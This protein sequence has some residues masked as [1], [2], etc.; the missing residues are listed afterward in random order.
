MKT[1]AALLLAT[2]SLSSTLNGLA[3]DTKP[4]APTSEAKTEPKAKSLFDGKTLTGWETVDVGGSGEVSVEEGAILIAQGES[5]TGLIYKDL[6]SLPL[7][8]YEI[9]L[10]AK[11]TRG[12]DF[13]CGL[14]FPVGSH[15]TSVTLVMGGWGGSV[16]GIS[17][18]DGLDADENSTSSFQRYADDT[19]YKLKVQVRAKEIKAWLDEKEIVNVDTEGK[20]LGLRPGPIESY[21]GFSLTAYNTEAHLRNIQIKP[22]P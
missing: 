5:L 15:E 6:K 20:K 19:W 16:T 3:A 22:L 7:V 10:E 8:N 4:S 18:I 13:F 21:P 9:T 1:T 2:L 14:T 17:R 12:V 11:R